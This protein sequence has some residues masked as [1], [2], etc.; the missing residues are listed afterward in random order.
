MGFKNLQAFNLTLLGKQAWNL[1]TKPE[2]Q[3]T[4]LFKERYFPNCDFVEANIGHNPSYVWRC[5]WNWNS[6]FIVRGGCKW[7]NGTG[8]KINIWG[9]NWLNKGMPVTTPPNTQGA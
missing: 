6:K 8:E 4:K 3:I 9:K 1:V 5:M 7:S 2:S